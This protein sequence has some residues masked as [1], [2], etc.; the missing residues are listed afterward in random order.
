ML[1]VAQNCAFAG[2]GDYWPNLHLRVRHVLLLPWSLSTT[3]CQWFVQLLPRSLQAK[4]TA[5]LSSF[6]ANSL[7][8]LAQRKVAWSWERSGDGAFCSQRM[9]C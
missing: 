7:H 4:S 3:A 9:T 5:S 6:S 2:W 1:S 8:S